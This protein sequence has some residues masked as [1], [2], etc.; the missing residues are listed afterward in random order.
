MFTRRE[1]LVTETEWLAATDPELMLEVVIEDATDRKLRL[2]GVACCRRIPVSRL[3]ERGRAAIEV[4]ER[5]AEGEV[6]EHDLEDARR[7]DSEA[8]DLGAFGGDDSWA[9]N[10]FAAGAER[11]AKAAAWAATWR[12]A[13]SVELS[14]A[15]ATAA[16]PTWDLRTR[17]FAAQADF[18]RCIFGN[19]FRSAPVVD[20]MWRQGTVQDLAQ[21]VY[22][23]RRLPEN[24][25]DPTRLATLADALE[26]A[27]CADAELLGH[28]R[29][30]GP[31]V[32]G[33]WAVDMLLGRS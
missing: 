4:A 2:F 33:C 24:T 28:L 12:H 29:G 1:M 31:H 16:V 22:Q 25:L 32:R 11:P 19:P 14:D 18:L 13:G 20:A 6:G 17:E 30:P 8:A 23:E 15:A 27:G 3:D 21:A 10:S 26:D 7:A 5:Y 9:R